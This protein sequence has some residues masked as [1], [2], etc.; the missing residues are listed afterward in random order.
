MA[1][2]SELQRQPLVF[3]C[4]KTFKDV[5]TDVKDDPVSQLR[6]AATKAN[7]AVENLQYKLRIVQICHRDQFLKLKKLC[8]RWISYPLQPN[9]ISFIKSI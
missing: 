5:K 8:A 1:I 6:I 7:V 3:R 2:V 9:E 4:H